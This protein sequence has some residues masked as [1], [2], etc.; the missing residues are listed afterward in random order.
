MTFDRLC[1]HYGMTLLGDPF[2]KPTGHST[3]IVES[4]KAVTPSYELSIKNTF[5]TQQV[6]LTLHLEKTQDVRMTLYDCI[7]RTVSEVAKERLNAGTHYLT[8]NMRDESGNVLPGGI[9]ILRAT[10]GNNTLMR[11]ILKIE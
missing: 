11:K 3:A 9:Y 8:I 10:I 1:W 2:L 6:Y 7:G 4:S 5:A